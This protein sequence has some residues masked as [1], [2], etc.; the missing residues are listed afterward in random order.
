MRSV[1]WC[2]VTEALNQKEKLTVRMRVTEELT[3]QES[4][5]QRRVTETRAF[6]NNLPKGPGALCTNAGRSSKPRDEFCGQEVCGIRATAER[7]D[8]LRS[9]L[10]SKNL[11]RGFD[12]EVIKQDNSKSW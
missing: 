8:S 6:L 3:L 4:T 1:V 2:C 5:M 12:K 11:E 10:G 7:R 9:L